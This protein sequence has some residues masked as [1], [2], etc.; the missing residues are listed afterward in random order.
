MVVAREYD[1]IV[2]YVAKAVVFGHRGFSIA[3][4][5]EHNAEREYRGGEE[6]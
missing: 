4:R 3:R 2:H 6:G 1:E 5:N